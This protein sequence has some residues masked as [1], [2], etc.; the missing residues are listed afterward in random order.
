MGLLFETRVPFESDGSGTE[1]IWKPMTMTAEE[2]LIKQYR[3]LLSINRLA[4]ILDRSPDDLRTMLRCSGEW[5][6]KINA[7]RLRP[8]RRL[9]FRT[10]E[11]ADVFGVR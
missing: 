3:P 5:V 10:V 6:N 2:T 8:G 1:R 4:A 9:H 11:V 7:T